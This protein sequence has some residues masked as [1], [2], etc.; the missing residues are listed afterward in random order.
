MKE[1]RHKF[2]AEEFR[3]FK[4]VL[5]RMLWELGMHKGYLVQ[6]M[7]IQDTID[8]YRLIELHNDA[9]TKHFE[10]KMDIDNILDWLDDNRIDDFDTEAILDRMDPHE[11]DL[12]DFFKK[13]KFK[14]LINSMKFDRYMEIIDDVQLSD[15][16]ELTAKYK[17]NSLEAKNQMRMVV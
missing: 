8:V 9:I 11:R 16:D 5:M 14:S 1:P 17:P 2:T 6:V 12:D 7:K 10:K 4:D 15:L 13:H 3:G